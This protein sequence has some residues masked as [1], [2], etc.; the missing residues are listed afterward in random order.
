MSAIFDWFNGKKT[1]FAAL[2][3]IFGELWMYADG[4]ATIQE[5]LAVIVPAVIGAFVRHGISTAAK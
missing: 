3:T 4:K 5:A 1:Y 2:A